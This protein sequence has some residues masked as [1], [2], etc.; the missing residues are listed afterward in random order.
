MVNRSWKPWR[1]WQLAIVAIA[2]L[3]TS[4]CGQLPLVSEQPSFSQA[5]HI[6]AFVPKQALLS[7]VI[8]TT[9]KLDKARTQTHLSKVV[10]E[11]LD[12]LLVS[13]GLDF[14]EDIRPWL[15]DTLAFAVTDK[16]IDRD[17]RNGRQTGYLLVVDAADGDRLREFLE[18]FWQR[19]TV[20]GTPPVLSKA[21]GVP[22]V[23]GQAGSSEQSLATAVVGQHTLLV[24]N[25]TQ[26]LK[27]SMRVAQ[28]PTLQISEYDCCVP[29]WVNLQLPE[30][31]DWLGLAV[32]VQQQ[33]PSSPQWHQLI[34]TA[35]LQPHRLVV[36]AQG[37]SLH[38]QTADPIV[39]A[40]LEN[41]NPRGVESIE[42]YLPASLVWAAAGYDLRPLWTQ[43][44]DELNYYQKLPAPIQQSQQ[45]LSTQL[46]QI[47][48]EPITQLFSNDYAVG[49]FRD[50][51]W[52]MAIANSQ[53]ASVKQL[54]NI[55]IQQGL[56]VSQFTLKE[57]SVTAW[58]RLKTRVKEGP[59][60][61]TTVE[62]ELVALHTRAKDCHIFAT[63]IGGLTAALEASEHPLLDTQKFQQV[64]QSIN[65][66]NQGYL[67]GT[68]DEIERLLASNRWFSLVKPILQPWTESLSAIAVSTHGQPDKQSTGTVSILLK[69]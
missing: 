19:Q 28:T 3:L 29:A 26:V 42:N 16:D 60:R 24:A 51:T 27:Q 65:N 37:K 5:N 34:T 44:G 45:W 23:T 66:H 50:G 17:H 62:T 69:D 4:G 49:Q 12:S 10:S 68:W 13:F 32:P 47:L 54:D 6:A 46:A 48:L 63:S 61:E 20:A 7:A 36:N 35:V 55:A 30:L 64:M 8:D 21:S 2:V 57:Q 43:L 9:A 39:T 25:D 38:H 31:M 18:L 33:L 56:T 14:K 58:S 53:P 15:G 22:I 11:K 41:T 67:Y 59:N 1:Y 40:N 52:L